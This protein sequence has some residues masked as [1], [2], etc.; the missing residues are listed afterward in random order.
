MTCRTLFALISAA[1]VWNLPNI[2]LA[3]AM[4]GDSEQTL[5]PATNAKEVGSETDA[6]LQMQAKKP[7]AKGKTPPKKP[8][9]PAKGAKG[10]VPQKPAPKPANRFIPKPGKPA[11]RPAAPKPAPFFP[12]APPVQLD[13][14]DN[15]RFQVPMPEEKGDLNIWGNDPTAVPLGSSTEARNQ[16]GLIGVGNYLGAGFG[17]EYLRRSFTWMDW[18]LQVT[19]TQTRLTNSKN[20][21]TDEFLS[22]SMTSARLATRFFN[23]R[24]L[25]VGVG[26]SVNRLEGR[27]GWEGPGVVD[28]EI[29]SDFKAQLVVLDLVLGSQWEPGKG[30]Y[31]GIDWLGLGAPLAGAIDYTENTDLDD[32]TELLTG[33]KTDE[34][35]QKE[36]GAQFRP[37]YALL[38]FGY[39]L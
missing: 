5:D 23:Q 38:K 6:V 8:A 2:T 33:S 11:P 39:M 12:P 26:L 7:P 18:G 31:I 37:Y 29:A 21:E 13:P 17:L 30:F 25:H 10:K 28:E 3:Q 36:L 4:Q 32:L 16:F 24:W 9:A 34:R 15:S 20:P 1:M 14:V 19:R 35:I 22:T 27:Y